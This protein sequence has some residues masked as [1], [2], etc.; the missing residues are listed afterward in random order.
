M[1]LDSYPTEEELEKIK[2]WDLIE[3][4]DARHPKL[5]ALLD[6]V[7]SLWMYDDRF[8]LTHGHYTRWH[9]TYRTLYLSTGGWSGNE[10]IIVALRQNFI[11]WSMFWRQSR[12]G[13]HYWF[14]IPYYYYDNQVHNIRR[15]K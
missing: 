3:G 2:T 10:S 14:E 7:Q 12:R 6:Y 15:H 9:R 11:F 5:Y 1:S 4:N 8:N 13:G